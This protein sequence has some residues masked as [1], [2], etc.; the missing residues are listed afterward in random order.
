MADDG[1]VECTIAVAIENLAVAQNAP[2]HHVRAAAAGAI[3]A[4]GMASGNGAELDNASA[5]DRYATAIDNRAG[6]GGPMRV[7]V[8]QNGVRQKA[9]AA[10]TDGAIGARSDGARHDAI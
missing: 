4:V 3:R 5:A 10:D 9:G 7:A 6:A 1:A 8:A 2:F